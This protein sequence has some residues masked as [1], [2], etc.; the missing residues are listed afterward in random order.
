MVEE[1]EQEKARLEAMEVAD[2]EQLEEPPRPLPEGQANGDGSQ[3]SLDGQAEKELEDYL[4]RGT[5]SILAGK[6]ETINPQPAR[7]STPPP[8]LRRPGTIRSPTSTISATIAQPSVRSTTAADRPSTSRTTDQSSTPVADRPHISHRPSTTTAADRSTRTTADR[9]STTADRP[10]T[11]TTIQPSASRSRGH[12]GWLPVTSTPIDRTTTTRPIAT[13]RMDPVDRPEVQGLHYRTASGKRRKYNPRRH[14]Q[15]DDLPDPTKKRAIDST[16][17]TRTK[18]KRIEAIEKDD[19]DAVYIPNPVDSEDSDFLESDGCDEFEDDNFS[20]ANNSDSEVD[21]FM[22]YESYE[23]V[24]SNYSTT[25]KK[26]ENN[27]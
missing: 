22:H 6:G 8:T 27:Y 19:V 12:P 9:P 14:L 11:S 2:Q 17:V 13:S 5:E 26:L 25:Q 23:K 7:T 21:G 20:E 4:G 24:L 3:L 16:I 10:S 15:L 1:I 18:K